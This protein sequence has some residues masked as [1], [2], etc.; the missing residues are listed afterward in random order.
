MLDL[1]FVSTYKGWQ[2]WTSNLKLFLVEY[3][4]RDW[5]STVH[6]MQNC[7][8]F[9]RK[10]HCQQA[11]TT[12]RIPYVQMGTLKSV[13]MTLKTKQQ[14]PYLKRIS[15][16]L[17]GFKK[18]KRK[19]EFT[20]EHHWQQNNKI[21]ISKRDLYLVKRLLKS[22]PQKWTAKVNLRIK[23]TKREINGRWRHT[24]AMASCQYFLE[25]S[26]IWFSYTD[27]L[28]IKMLRISFSS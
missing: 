19:S 25:I 17:K 11:C 20:Y 2:V 9:I 3:L 23:V 18:G 28:Y 21:L 5:L 24:P 14:N 27:K 1:V 13:F 4:K 16:L 22:E 15:I 8:I 10:Y 26:M 6:R 7:K 12:L